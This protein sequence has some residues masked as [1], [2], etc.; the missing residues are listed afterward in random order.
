MNREQLSRNA[1]FKIKD[2]L[3]RSSRS[4]NAREAIDWYC[5]YFCN[6]EW[7]AN[8]ALREYSNGNYLGEINNQ[9]QRSGMGLYLFNDGDIY[10]GHWTCNMKNG[11]GFYYSG[12]DVT[13]GDWND[14]KIERN[15]YDN[16]RKS[17][18]SSSSSSSKS[19]W[20]STVIVIII[21]FF[22]LRFLGCIDLG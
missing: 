2:V 20:I 9:G 14:G 10:L 22:V 17:Y 6:T 3:G 13:F 21:L 15:S 7:I 19:S 5:S 16:S 1:Y 11:E 12:G 8:A 18:T 4:D